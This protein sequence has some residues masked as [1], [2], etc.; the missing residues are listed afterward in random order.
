MGMVR[1]NFRR[2]DKEDFLLIYKTYIRNCIE[3]CVQAWSLHL[4]NDIECLEKV[5]RSATKMV[6]GLRH[7][8]YEQR[9]LHL[10]ITTLQDESE[11][12]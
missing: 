4:K 5:Q 6:H 12:I 11:V 8:P 2:L 7:L 3:Y 9:L 1:R 10:G